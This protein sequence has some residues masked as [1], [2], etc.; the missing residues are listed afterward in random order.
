VEGERSEGQDVRAIVGTEVGNAAGVGVAKGKKPAG[1][2]GKAV[3]AEG[4]E[5]PVCVAGKGVD[6][7]CELEHEAVVVGAVLGISSVGFDLGLQAMVEPFPTEGAPAGGVVVPRKHQSSSIK[8]GGFAEEVVVVLCAGVKEGGRNAGGVGGD[9]TPQ[10]GYPLGGG[11]GSGSENAVGEGEGYQA[12]ANFLG[13][14][15]VKAS[16]GRVCSAEPFEVVPK[17]GGIFFVVREDIGAGKGEDPSKAGRFPGE[18]NV[19]R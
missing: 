5:C 3:Q 13:R 15:P 19:G 11:G 7:Q 17:R 9:G 10:V 1:G 2:S 12:Q 16:V 6:P 18:F 8:G 14:D 4:G